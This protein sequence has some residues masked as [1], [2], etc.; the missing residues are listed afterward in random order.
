M[1]RIAVTMCVLATLSVGCRWGTRIRLYEVIRNTRVEGFSEREVEIEAQ[2]E[3]GDLLLPSVRVPAQEREWRLQETR[4]PEEDPEDVRGDGAEEQEGPRVDA[5]YPEATRAWQNVEGARREVVEWIASMTEPWAWFVTLTFRNRQ[6]SVQGAKVR[7]LQWLS[8]FPVGEKPFGRVVF[9]VEKQFEGTA[10]IHA[11][12]TETS[13]PLSAHCERC[14][15]SSKL[16]DPR[17]RRLKES[18]FFHAGIARF[19]PYR[20]DIGRGGIAYVMKYILSD[21]C[22]DWGILDL[23]KEI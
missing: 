16:T 18:W 22:E 14:S 3:T 2:G 6:T 15:A 7:L 17:W 1:R 10:H 21:E 19:L 13:R 11:L 23:G 12:M 8:K 5:R 4:P 20:D 9:S